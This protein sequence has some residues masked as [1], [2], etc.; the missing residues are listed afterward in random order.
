MK[1]TVKKSL[2][3]ILTLMMLLSM[4]PGAVFAAGEML[5]LEL[6]TVMADPG[7]TKVLVPVEA[8]VNTGI[9]AFNLVIEYDH[10]ALEL[11]DVIRTGSAVLG[12]AMLYT[13][14]VQYD[15]I[16]MA[17]FSGDL[18]GTGSF[19]WLEFTVK[20]DAEPGTYPINIVKEHND[21]KDLTANGNIDV[22][23]H[24]VPG[25]VTVTGTT[26]PPV[27]TKYEV[28]F[29]GLPAG[30]NIT[31]ATGTMQP[32]T[33]TSF[34]VY[35]MEPGNYTYLIYPNWP[36]F[37]VEL[38]DNFTVVDQDIIFDLFTPAGPIT[39]SSSYT[40]SAG[41][42]YLIAPTLEQA[43]ITVT[44]TEAVTLV[45]S[46]VENAANSG[47]TIQYNVVAANL[48][49]QDLFISGSYGGGSIIDFVGLGNKLTF[50]GTSMMDTTG[51]S[52]LSLIHVP[53]NASLTIDGDA[54]SRVYLYKSSGSSCIG[55][56]AMEANGSITFAG[57][58]IFAKGSQQG[59]VIGTGNS[60]SVTPGDIY[61]TG[62]TLNL[63]A[64]A[65]GACIGGG[66]GSSGATGGGNVYISGGSLNI[67]V[68]FSGAAIGGGGYA[69]GNDSSG[70]FLYVS[71][72]SLRT[73]LDT[74]AANNVSW[75]Y[76]E[77]G[78]TP[79]VITAKIADSTGTPAYFLP[80]DTDLLDIT[81]TS[82]TVY[83]DGAAT[84]FYSGGLHGFYYI[85]ET[86]DKEVGQLPIAN[87]MANWEPLNGSDP[88]LYFY[89]TG[90]N[91]TLTVN[92]E[93]FEY[94]WD[95]ESES[96]S[97]APPPAVDLTLWDG[98]IDTSWYNSTDTTFTLTTAAQFAG[99]A[100]IVN[101]KAANSNAGAVTGTNT[102]IPADDFLGKTV[103]LGAN[104]DLGG[105]MTS[106]GSLVGTTYTAPVWT[107]LMWTPIGSYT[108][109]GAT[110]SNNGGRGRPFKGTFD[111]GFHTLSNVYIK[112]NNAGGF[113]D[114]AD[115]SHAIFG[116]LGH[117]GTVKN[118]IV[119]SGYIRGDRF[120]AGIAG[121]NWG[122]VEYC[123]NFA[124]IETDGSRSGGGISGV[125]YDNTTGDGHTPWIK[126]SYN[127]GLVMAGDNA[128]GGGIVNDN[129][130][131][132]ENC[133][134]VGTG[135]RKTSMSTKIGGIEGGDRSRGTIINSYSITG[136]G[137]PTLLSAA[138]T[139]PAGTMLTAAEMQTNAFV[140]LLGDAFNVV[141]GGFPVLA[142]QGGTP[143][144]VP[145]DK[146]ALGEAITAIAEP[147]DGNFPLEEDYTAES[148]APFETAVL[149]AVSV[150]QDDDATQA[151]VD[152]ALANLIAA[153][154][155]LE[156]LPAAPL[157]WDGTVDVRW[158][159]TTDKVFYIST[160]AEWAGLAAIVNGRTDSADTVVLG[161][162]GHIENVSANNY[163]KDDFNGKT[164]YL[165]A[166]LNM[167]GVESG[168][169]WSGPNYT[170]VGGQYT[171]ASGVVLS[172]SFCG[173]FDG[174]GHKVYNIYCSRHSSSYGN[175]Q[176]VGLFGRL[177]VHDNDPATMRPVNPTIRNV[178][179][180]GYIY[181]NRSVGGIV[182]KIGKTSVNNGDGSI[183]GII[184]NCANFA[185]VKNTD[186][187]GVGGIVG[188]GWNGGIVRN[189]F[190]A[191]N[192][193]S[194]YNDPVAGISA[195]NE[196]TIENCYNI[197]TIT[198]PSANY[199]MAIG[200][201]NGGTYDI[202]NNYWLTGSAVGGGYYS[203]NAAH[204]AGV[205]EKT[206]AEM[207]TPEFLAALNNGGRAYIF[208]A[209]ENNGYPVLRSH[210]ADTSTLVGY[211]K[212]SDPAKLSYVEGQ[213]FSTAGMAV[214]ANY[215]DNSYEA[216]TEFVVSN[217]A[218][219]TVTDTT[220][221]VVAMYKGQ[222]VGSYEYTITVIGNELDS[223]AVTTQPTNR[224]YANGES[225]NPAGMVVRAT[226][227]NGSVAT[228]ANTDYSFS[229]E[230]LT[231]G[232]SAVTVSYTYGEI[233]KTAE[234][235]VTVSE[236]S[237]PTQNDDGYYELKTVTDLLWFA[238]QVNT[239]VNVSINGKLMNNIDLSGT[240][241]TP[242]GTLTTGKQF[243]G[244]FDGN[245]CTVTL[246]HT[247]TTT[248]QGFFGYMAADSSVKDLTVEGT[249]SGTGSIGAIAGY[250]LG[251]TIENCVNNA[252][253]NGT[254]NYVGGVVGYASSTT[255]ENCVNN[256]AVVSTSYNVGGIAAYASPGTIKNCVNN[257]EVKGTYNVGGIVG[258]VANTSTITG[259]V[260][261]AA[262]T[263][264]YYVGGIVG[265]Q[266]S[267]DKVTMCANN[268]DITA[269]ATGTTAAYGVGGISGIM[270][271]AGLI[272]SCVNTGKI[273]GTVMSV[274]G[275]VGYMTAATGVVT[276]SYNTG[277]VTST[278]SSA[279]AT[280]GGIVG[281]V[282]N[283]SG[284]VKNTFSTGTV[285]YITST[286]AAG[287]VGYAAGITNIANNFF[288]D[289]TASKALGFNTAYTAANAAA[290]NA[291]ALAELAETLGAAF[292]TGENTPILTW[293]PDYTP[294]PPVV[295]GDYTFTLVADKDHYN[296]G[297]TM[298]V[299][300]VVSSEVYETLATMQLRLAYDSSLLDYVG[301]K[302]GSPLT[303]A[304]TSTTLTL[305]L[306]D[307][308]NDDYL[309]L[310]D[311]EC[312]VVT[313]EFVVLDNFEENTEATVSIDSTYKVLAG[314]I[315]LDFFAPTPTVVP[316]EALTTDVYNLI[317]TFVA[318]EGVEDFTAA[319]AHVK[320]G[321]SK[322]YTDTT[323]TTEYTLPE[324]TAKT[325]Y[326]NP[327]WDGYTDGDTFTESAEI[328]ATATRLEY[329]VTFYGSDGSVVDT[330]IVRYGEYATT[331][332]APAVPGMALE[333]WF[334]VTAADAVY[335]DDELLAADAIDA[336]AV[337]ANISYKAYYV[338]NMFEITIPDNVTIISG[339][340][341][342]DDVKYATKGT[343][344]TFEVEFKTGHV[345]V[346]TV[347]IG[348]ETM[349]LTPDGDGVYTIDGDMITGAV[350]IDV[351]Y[352]VDGQITF[353]ENIEYNA[354]P[355]GY[356]V[357]LL[358][359]AGDPIE[360]ATYKY[361]DTSFLW[362]EKYE[363][364]VMMVDEDLT[365][366]E[367]IEDI[368]AEVI[369][370]ATLNLTID[371][372]GDLVKP[373]GVD[374]F[375]AQ[376]IYNLYRGV[377]NNGF[378]PV[379]EQLRLMADVNG[380]GAVD[381]QD[382]NI[383]LALG[384]I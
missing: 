106:A 33:A 188:A 95:A 14:N 256:G 314:P 379:T 13:A 323:W 7:D 84:P 45:G 187:K 172:A 236:S 8:S 82:F 70:G 109:S 123:A 56:N 228:I 90:K 48:T 384:D 374:I 308:L 163:G 326:E 341:T 321:D 93:V 149:A 376:F 262:V 2:A 24:T 140:L 352:L 288:L 110:E 62:G 9:I 102:A 138:G 153:L 367:A 312:V 361:G 111:G 160:P 52:T 287:V 124:T 371:Y 299:D 203:N 261:N 32:V 101:N 36:D 171:T 378:D 108:G 296:V 177:G 46:G 339:V 320:Y 317:V 294:E 310:T 134:N 359:L 212:T 200:S 75:N 66:A 65:R 28:S 147:E 297:E 315:N 258:N 289:T 127:A 105:V 334:V 96:F 144:T 173:T 115:N 337:T 316:G 80:F 253:V 282:N 266:G 221:T 313:L 81:A 209:G 342:V 217:T 131:I 184:E 205:I 199:A 152:A 251:A 208:V 185:T 19:A 39:I 91:H 365:A 322:L 71:G 122:H 175:G 181:S 164:I 231:A 168:G 307:L 214:R 88:N 292:K 232:A 135:A 103:V 280:V 298:S 364:Y 73:Y 57:G 219:L 86:Y 267:A 331:P 139:T 304:E 120:T 241:W 77:A 225:F 242:I 157:V 148:W 1:K 230:V 142:G 29:P 156:L 197:G 349:T 42:T 363:A 311:D 125:L 27:P 309:T 130:G 340:T 76:A 370:S 55:G 117:D 335:D 327:A 210:Y 278:A 133:F 158:Y 239:G 247:A 260:N 51:W 121:R 360:N 79:V 329:T 196:I 354:A 38:T 372:N 263:G 68:D 54:T 22:A 254:S 104:L 333:G 10:D 380:D 59:A 285:S 31:V 249:L 293:E 35:N 61:I 330:Q 206:S 255:I 190:N 5:A 40:I 15:L 362:S 245:G 6:G 176:S 302:D 155:A 112:G 348:G 165:T 234:V 198:A 295:T 162:A 167:G 226:Y 58:N 21:P 318:G 146:T 78:V 356:K 174:Q 382:V 100:A 170:P 23:L 129:E 118:L 179:V 64:V 30:A 34:G 303:V 202:I 53:N 50:K 291:E 283:A 269:T 137:Y 220:I 72:G 350:S 373:D 201:N 328:T 224:F 128:Y 240:T 97:I 20:E 43:T 18:T 119:G 89:L 192:I 300:V 343:D 47:V 319:P 346:V 195:Y 215:S 182:G 264:T 276:N 17:N 252:A 49:I 189:C 358:T 191:G 143:A 94:I 275:I 161:D 114:I 259:N 151:E 279:N 166:D 92:G 150:Y 186:A 381:I 344:I 271:A 25:S 132:V 216:V 4:I 11:T 107:G 37:S 113:D 324:L 270:Y 383:V 12:S 229:P 265:Y 227:T 238:N 366:A 257:G 126:N 375:D 178:S 85:N 357:M 290:V 63:I 3:I 338:V 351:T 336:A 268:G 233:T 353:I 207:K 281:R 83:V 154:D 368:T 141:E 222:Q 193:S 325:G 243:K 235:A 369:G 272:D 218:P 145:V 211:E 273:S 67:N 169:T 194:T 60:S 183:G 248:Y 16:T 159:N 377:Y 98:T 277:G 116:D 99:L 244:T 345:A 223:I 284:T 246:S 305:R 136:E 347:S 44:T 87:T 274:G 69:E 286:Y 250:A 180:Y 74:N 332:A 213:T 237:A 204:T 41:G 355:E 301:K 26:T 306:L